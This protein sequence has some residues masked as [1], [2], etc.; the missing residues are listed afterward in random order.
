MMETKLTVA[1]FPVIITGG[2]FTKPVYLNNHVVG[3]VRVTYDD[4]STEH[5]GFES[6]EVLQHSVP[7]V[8]QEAK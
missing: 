5:I 3:Q 7:F 2:S 6:I 8:I 4:L 1:G